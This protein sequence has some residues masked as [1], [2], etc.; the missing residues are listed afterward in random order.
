M[1]LYMTYVKKVFLEHCPSHGREML[2]MYPANLLEKHAIEYNVRQIL[3]NLLHVLM[4]F[5][6]RKLT[7]SADL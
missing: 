6:T 3:T 5:S 4:K 1:L 7:K 2:Q